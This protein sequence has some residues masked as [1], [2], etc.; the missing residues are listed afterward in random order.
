MEVKRDTDE[1][2]LG[3]NELLFYSFPKRKKHK[4]IVN[5]RSP[6]DKNLTREN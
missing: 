1:I 2:N 4:D 3:D 6:K 5:S